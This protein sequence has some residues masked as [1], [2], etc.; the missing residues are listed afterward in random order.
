MIISNDKPEQEQ[1]PELGFFAMFSHALLS[2]LGIS[3][4]LLGPLPMILSALKL[5]QPWP[6][7]TSLLGAVLALVVL[8]APV[9]PVLATFVFGL[10][11]AESAS[12]GENFWKLLTKAVLLAAGMGAL[13]LFLAARFEGA[14][15]LPFWGQLVDSVIAQL[16]TAVSGDA[17]FQWD[18]VRALLFYEGPFLLLSGAVL[19]LWFSVGAAAHLG[20][21]GEGHELSA[22]RLREL[23]LPP[24]FSVAFV[25]LF[26]LLVSGVAGRFGYLGGVFRLLG[27]IVFIQGCVALSNLMAV[28]QIAPRVRTLIYTVSILVGFYAVVGMGV[29]GPW[30]YRKRGNRGGGRLFPRH[31]EEGT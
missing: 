26:V 10:V 5:E 7:I 20:W 16:K 18:A 30:L 22:D 3:S 12:A 31:L 14:S 8:R 27:S 29:M 1:P 15:P 4:I 6:R 9:G 11:V 23:R 21:F 25:A 13:G 24:W 17:S 28:R 19:S 2:A